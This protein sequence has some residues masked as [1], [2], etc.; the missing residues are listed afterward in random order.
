MRANTHFQPKNIIIM[1]FGL[2]LLTG[3]F[4]VP[5]GTDVYA[6]PKVTVVIDPGH[7]GRSD[8]EDETNSGA[9]YHGL[10]EKDLTLITALSMYDEL[11]EYGNVDVYLTRDIDAPL[12]LESRVEFAEEVGADVLIS[13]HYNAS[14]DHNFFGS[15]VFTSAYGDCYG[16]GHSLAE[17]V[18]DEWVAEGS[19]P[20]D[21]KTRI[22]KNGDYYGLIR[23]GAAAGIPT[24]ILEH[25]YLDNDRDYLRIKN[26]E[27]WR[28]FGVL[29]AT[30]VAKY[31]GL[32]KDIVKENIGPEFEPE[33]PEDPVMPDDSGPEGVRLEIDAYN[34]NK[35]DVDFTLY[36]KDAESKLMYYGFKTGDVD[37]DTV[38]EELELW[39]G[40]NGKVS[41]TYHLQPGYKGP[42]TAKVYNVYQVDTLSNTVELEP[43][44]LAPDDEEDNAVIKDENATE[45][46][47]ESEDTMFVD[48]I[49]PE[50][51]GDW[52]IGGELPAVDTTAVANAIDK[53]TESEVENSFTGLLIVAL[54]GAIVLAVTVVI[55]TSLAAEKKRQRRNDRRG[56][57]RNSHDWIDEYDDDY[58]EKGRR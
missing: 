37:K 36:A 28:R 43:D 13:I 29:D 25:G 44:E 51:D 12:T 1:I 27:A 5:S 46:T 49:E 21:I 48:K 9:K 33:S 31:Y 57:Q 10:E 24:I 32:E 8:A 47:A 23:F 2:L 18:M 40:K 26:A 30:A 11:C 45:D 38:F 34:S 39:D 52:I 41:G 15:E 16:V 58:G 56:Y 3:A 4:I 35:G 53:N 19:I 14:A 54:V 50:S 20:K 55:C 6:S 7:G 22:G 42:I 17:Y